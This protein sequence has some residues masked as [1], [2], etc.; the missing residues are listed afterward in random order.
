MPTFVTKPTIRE[1]ESRQGVNTNP[2]LCTPEVFFGVSFQPTHN[3]AILVVGSLISEFF[4]RTA[5]PPT[6]NSD[7][8]IVPVASTVIFTSLRPRRKV[9]F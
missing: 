7:R 8:T 1:S 6:P 5:Q 9:H 2:D 3:G 4:R